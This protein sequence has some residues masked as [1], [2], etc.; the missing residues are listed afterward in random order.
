MY[1]LAYVPPDTEM[2]VGSLIVQLRQVDVIHLT[3]SYNT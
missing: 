3:I 2:L 1:V